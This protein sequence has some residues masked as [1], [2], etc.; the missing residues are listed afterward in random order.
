MTLNLNRRFERPA[1]PVEGSVAIRTPALRISGVGKRF[2][3]LV[4]NEDV[5]FTLNSGQVLALLGE[6]G[7][8]KTPLMNILFG[9]YVADHGTVEVNGFPLPPGSSQA[10]LQAGVGMVHQHFAL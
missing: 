10:A 7:A 4:A 6:N 2:G 1:I 9:H 3:S 8:G 5:S